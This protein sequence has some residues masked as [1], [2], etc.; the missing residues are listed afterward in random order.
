GGPPGPR[1]HVP[2]GERPEHTMRPAEAAVGAVPVVVAPVVVPERVV[3]PVV[4]MVVVDR[5]VEIVVVGGL[6]GRILA[7]KLLAARGFPAPGIGTAF[8][9][10]LGVVMLLAMLR[11]GLLATEFLVV[12]FRPAELAL[13]ATA[14]LTCATEMPATA[15]VAATARGCIS[16]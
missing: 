14:E 7:M 10:A 3:G 8:L 6:V 2:P 16:S 5:V 15:E 4:P 13:V 9:V 11:A 12:L 1:P